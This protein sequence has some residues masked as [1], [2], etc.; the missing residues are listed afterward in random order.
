MK[1]EDIPQNGWIYGLAQGDPFIEDHV[2]DVMYTA[3]NI[4]DLKKDIITV[5]SDIMTECAQII[6]HANAMRDD[7]KCT[8]TGDCGDKP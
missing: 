7:Q 5:M 1:I 8:Y 2:K 4:N 3:L 6:Q